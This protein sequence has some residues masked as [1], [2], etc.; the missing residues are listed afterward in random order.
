[1]NAKFF[2]LALGMFTLPL[3]AAPLT[4]G[5][6]T[7]IIHEVNTLSP[8]GQATPAKVTFPATSSFYDRTDHSLLLVGSWR[9]C[10]HALLQP[11]CRLQYTAT[12]RDDFLQT[13]ALALYCP[14]TE[15]ITLRAYIKLRQPEHRRFL[16]EE[17]SEARHRWRIEPHG[18]FLKIISA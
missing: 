15:R 14:L 11:S 5:T 3:V 16:L 6:F 18:A 7:E 13:L 9:L 1:M 2:L 4:S 17:L 10:Q 12:S 8:S